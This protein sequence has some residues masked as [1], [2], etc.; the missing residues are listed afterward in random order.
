N[1]T[2]A[3]PTNVVL[4]TDGVSVGAA[5]YDVALISKDIGLSGTPTTGTALGVNAIKNDAFTNTGAVSLKVVYQ[6]TPKSAAGCSGLPFTITV[7]VNP[8]PVVAALA[9]TVC[10][11]APSGITLATNGS[12]VGAASYKLISVTF[13]G[14]I[15]ADAGN[16]AN[17]GLPRTGGVGLIAND[18]YTN[19]TSGPVSVSYSIMGISGSGCQGQVQAITLTINPEP[20]LVPGAVTTCSGVAAGAAINLGT[21]TG[22]VPITQYNLKQVFVPDSLTASGT[23]A[24]LGNYLVNNFLSNDKFT[25]VTKNSWQVTYTIAPVASGCIGNDYTVTLT[26]DPAPAVANL[27]V[28]VCTNSA[29]GIKL[30]SATTGVNATSFSIVNVSIAAGLIQTAG[31]NGVRHGVTGTEIQNDK[32][33]NTTNGPL[34]V[35]YTVV[36]MSAS[37]CGGPTKDVVLTVEPTIL[38]TP[39]SSP[40]ICSN[41]SLNKTATNFTLNSPSAPTAG[42]ITFSYTASSSVGGSLNGFSKT[43]SNLPNNTLIQ[44][45]LVN[46]AP[47]RATLIYTVTP[48]ANGAR[49]GAGCSG[50]PIT[51][52]VA[53]EPKPKLI[54]SPGVQTVCE[55]VASKIML[56]SNTIP[57]AG[58]IQFN[59]VSAAGEQ[60]LTMTSPSIPSYTDGQSIADI[61][62]ND[63]TVTKTAMYTL[64]PVIA[65][66]LGCRGDHVNVTLNVNPAPKV[67]ATM[68]S[69]TLAPAAICSSDLIDITLRSDVSSTINTWATSLTGGTV[70][71]AA[72]GSGDEIY[73]TPKNAGASPVTIRYQ[74]TPKAGGCVGNAIDVDVRVDP[75]PDVKFAAPT[76][77]CYG[78]TLNVPLTSSVSGTR[79]N[80]FVDPNNSGVDTAMVHLNPTGINQV[81]KDTLN[82]AQDI[83]TYTITAVGPGTTGC[84]SA[85]RSLTVIASPQMNGKFLNDNTSFCEGGK[86]FLQVQL[87]GQAP[88]TMSYTDGTNNFTLTKAGNFKSI[89]IKPTTSTTYQLTSMKDANGCSLAL[90]GQVTY[91]VYSNVAAGFTVGT[92]PKFV[93]GNATVVFTNTSA[94]LDAGQFTYKWAFGENSS[95]DS[96]SGAGPFSVNY[97]VPGSKV[98]TLEAY[99]TAAQAAGL[100]CA[101]SVTKTIT[102][103]LDPLVAEFKIDPKVACYPKKIAVTEN[104]STGDRF[105]WSVIDALSRDT[106]ASSNA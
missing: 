12:S 73:Q 95:P 38:A 32:F 14:T 49:D 83:L 50:S 23:N 86:D 66:G 80:W 19:S 81:V 1:P 84:T 85:Q 15:T 43:V 82:S 25:N 36:P 55:G 71:G 72:N 78:G 94:P 20:I 28:T 61:W 11:K 30:R 17:L 67:I 44:D 100:S 46:L 48:V 69:P 22:S 16:I 27:D 88:F 2:S 52:S 24:G 63:S 7:T 106:V 6:I 41:T 8:E 65:G 104:Q 62:R 79:F 77:V 90:N 87:D 37:N 53:V 3:N 29:S 51:I 92:V 4:G 101:H 89:S 40:G 97:A 33:N 57:G 5:S 98:V 64:Q 39:V 9:N 99:N 56:T 102:I 54:A 96:V 74:V 76:P 93:G 59:V 10:S 21:A 105:K 31:N 26:V 42:P 68:V 35:T 34:K 13:P 47:G 18:K 91:T 75:I 45:S 70:S 103:L 60:G 58:T